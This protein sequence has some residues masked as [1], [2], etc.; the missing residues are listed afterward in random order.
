[1]EGRATRA[2]GLTP[3]LVSSARA[4]A[5]AAANECGVEIFEVVELEEIDDVRNVINRIWGPEIVPPRN[6]LKAVTLAGSCV[7]LARRDHE[8]V[9]F[10]VGILGWDTGLHFHSHQVGVVASERGSGVGFSLKLAQRATCLARGITEMR[11]TFDPLLSSNAN[12]NFERLGATVLSFHP[13]CYGPRIDAFNTDD[14]TD[15]IRVSWRLDQPIGRSSVVPTKN[16]PS[17]I[18]T[19]PDVHRSWDAP[20][21]GAFIPIPADYQRLRADDRE[22]ADAWRIAMGVAL[23]DVYA[24]GRAL[25]GL[26]ASGY[27]VKGLL[28]RDDAQ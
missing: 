28:P 8:V 27:C 20:S 21:E 22:T 6:F 9:G 7:L 23:R 3:E 12:F 17:L 24:S 19:T 4:S 2:T 10:A 26:G 16:G 13:N 14:V 5:L 25:F 1:M 15:R 18:A 11:W